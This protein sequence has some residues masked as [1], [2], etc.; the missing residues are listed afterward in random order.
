MTRRSLTQHFMPVPGFV[1]EFGWICGYSAEAKF[2]D[3]AAERFTGQVAAMRARAG[4]IRLA[5]L[6]D[7]GNPQLSIA[8]VPGVVHCPARNMALPFRL[9]HAKVAI[10]GF[11]SLEDPGR[12]QLRLLVSTGN[13]TRATLEDNLDLAWRIDIDSD[14]LASANVELRRRCA[15]VDAAWDLMT[16]LRDHFDTSLL[17]AVPSQLSDTETLLAQRALE[18][19]LSAARKRSAGVARFFDNRGQ[20]LLANVRRKLAVEGNLTARNYLAMGSG[21]YEG[22]AS[23]GLPSVPKAIV[24]ALREGGLLTQTAGIELFA[25]PSACQAVATG[26]NAIKGEGWTVRPPAT[27]G[28]GN[29]FMHAKFLFSARHKDNSNRCS[30]A[31]SYLGSGNLTGPG[32]LQ[33]ASAQ[34]GNLEAGV[35]QSHE[36][37]YWEEM[38]GLEPSQAIGNL[39]PLQWDE[40][41]G[42]TSNLA[43]GDAMAG[44]EL[45][46]VAPP[47]SFLLWQPAQ[48]DRGWLC[49]VAPHPVLFEVR[50]VDGTP[51]PRETDGR[52][53]W[54]G[55]R[56]L[57][58]LI[59]WEMDG[60]GYQ[61]LAPVMDEH[62]R[63]AAAPMSGLGVEEAG[64]ELEGFPATTGEEEGDDDGDDGE[65]DGDGNGNADIPASRH[66]TKQYPIRQ[67]MAL[68][69]QIAEKQC[70]ISQIDWSAWCHRLEQV[71]ARVAGSD[72]LAAFLALELN[73]LSALYMPAFRPAYAESAV[74]EEGQRYEDALAR[75]E[76]AWNVKRLMPMGEH[77]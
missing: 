70:S 28:Y 24:D 75:I 4:C 58:V 10:L 49:S 72:S 74:S 59:A 29:R 44:R 34:R 61:A 57:Q 77:A 60:R 37:L 36:D 62:G 46:F 15:D 12:F 50:A 56:P 22:G 71:L 63:V 25:N 48:A 13:W 41:L 64:W 69:E 21:F 31:W 76:L 26:I 42:P 65:A 17:A 6:L 35:V 66:G 14:D 55:K 53:R 7:P 33:R 47:V 67:M 1:G 20:S 11:R 5:L 68:I 19:W 73:P 16:S 40:E 39:L 23:K 27:Q 45:Q 9:L 38:D 51:C 2:I 30:S 3:M 18:K 54:D 32:F 52:I 43:Q 8:E